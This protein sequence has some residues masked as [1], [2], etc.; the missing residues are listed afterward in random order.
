MPSKGRCRVRARWAPLRSTS[1]C[2]PLGPCSLAAL[3]S[4]DG[5]Q[6][7]AGVAEAVSDGPISFPPRSIMRAPAGEESQPQQ[8]AEPGNISLNKVTTSRF[9]PMINLVNNR[10][11]SLYNPSPAP[12]LKHKHAL[13][14]RSQ[15][16][17]KLSEVFISPVASP[18]FLKHP[19][20]SW[21]ITFS[22]GYTPRQALYPNS[23][24]Y[25]LIPPDFF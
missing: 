16:N 6:R 1:D 17:V 14:K 12:T 11:T 15:N 3:L 10:S 24:F 8:G 7:A 5:C 4:R 18:S 23:I 9:V 25:C 21:K 19:N 2:L 22:T 20:K 13:W